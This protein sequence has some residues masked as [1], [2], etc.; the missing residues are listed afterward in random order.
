MS[1]KVPY[2][3]SA[4]G[5]WADFVAMFAGV[6]LVIAGGFQMLQGLAAIAND[7]LYAQGS[8]YLYD[9]NMTAWGWVH[10]LI[11]AISVVVGVGIA[12]RQSWGQVSGMIVAVLSMLTNFAFLPHYPLWAVTVIA[13]DVLVIWAL[14][15]QLA[16]E[17]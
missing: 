10:L 7:D 4:K 6:L 17:G 5:A 9:F 2:E 8:G 1:T 15:T 11:G 12:I 3:Y 14:S 13:F 16:H